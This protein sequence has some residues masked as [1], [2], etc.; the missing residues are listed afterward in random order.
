MAEGERAVQAEEGRVAEEEDEVL[1]VAQ[2]HRRADPEAVVIDS[3]HHLARRAH[4]HRPL[5]L[6]EPRAGT[7]ARAARPA[8]KDERR[9]SRVRRLQLPKRDDL[10]QQ[11]GVAEQ[12][13]AEGELARRSLHIGAEGTAGVVANDDGPV[14]KD[15]RPDEGHG[16]CRREA[17]SEH[18]RR[19]GAAGARGVDRRTQL[20][21]GHL[22]PRL[23]AVTL[24]H[25]HVEPA[26]RL[27]PW[28]EHAKP[29][30]RSRAGRDGDKVNVARFR[31]SAGVGRA[32]G[33]ALVVRRG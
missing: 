3:E 16:K 18:A 23:F 5:G 8:T 11:D 12:D 31:V 28:Q 33:G 14:R 13:D 32:L 1:A 4:P 10:Q 21:H 19:Q 20:G 6:L 25:L 26:G 7:H 22:E 29:L 24:L 17:R 30:S 27:V 2:S 9:S 15:E